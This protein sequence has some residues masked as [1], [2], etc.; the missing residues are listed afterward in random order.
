MRIGIIVGSH[1]GESESAR[2]G[3]YLEAALQAQGASTYFFSLANNP[4][5]LWDESLWG[6]SEE[7]E[8][9][10]GPVS[11]ELEKCSSFVVISPEW[12]GMVPSG[13]KNLFLLAS[14]RELG[15]KP[16]LIVTVSSSAGG[17]YPVNELRT[18]SYKNTRLCYIPEHV[19][20]RNVGDMLKGPTA[21]ND[22]DRAIRERLEYSLKLLGQ[23]DRALAAVRE[24]GVIDHE[25][26][27]YGM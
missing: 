9:L 19:I 3:R 23:Y 5:P 6:K 14:T 24:S 11:T 12:S 15:H 22:R 1:R 21:A 16:A 18:S 2:V 10:W 25:N 7:W 27:P 20:I 13:L 4:L 26:F 8:R 17:S